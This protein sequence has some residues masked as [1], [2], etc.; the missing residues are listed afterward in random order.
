MSNVK[1]TKTTK[2]TTLMGR[3]PFVRGF[4]EAKAGKPFVYD[5]YPTIREA[6]QYALRQAVR[7]WDAPSSPHEELRP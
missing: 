1:S 7:T 6:V 5:A 4:N 2:L 3:A